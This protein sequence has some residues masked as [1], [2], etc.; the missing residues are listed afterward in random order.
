MPFADVLR[1]RFRVP[2]ETDP[3]VLTRIVRLA[4]GEDD[5]ERTDEG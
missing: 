1:Q 5:P 3:D 4:H 2:P